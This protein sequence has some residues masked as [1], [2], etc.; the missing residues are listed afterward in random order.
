[1][2]EH[3]KK[4]VIP[5]A[6]V[7]AS[8]GI[9]FAGIASAQTAPTSGAEGKSIGQHMRGHMAERGEH[10]GMGKGRGIEGTVTAVNGTT[11]TVAGENGTS[12]TID[13]SS[14]KVSK[15]T[16]IVI[17]DI[18]VGDTIGAR[19]AISGTTVTAKHIMSG[20]LPDHD[21]D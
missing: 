13:G 20:E 12:Y 17:G 16:T 8:I 9:G 4:A 19:G 10:G 15:I 1:M 14:A 6:A 3:I 18:K 2:K 21:Q 5:V 7:L 11:V